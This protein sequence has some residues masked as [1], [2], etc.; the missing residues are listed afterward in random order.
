MSLNCKT[1]S[2]RRPNP[3]SRTLLPSAEHKGLGA[4]AVKESWIMNDLKSTKES[5]SPGATI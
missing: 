1:R 4:T 5:E 3:L 2:D